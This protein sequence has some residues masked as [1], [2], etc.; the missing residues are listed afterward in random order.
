MSQS[1]EGYHPQRANFLLSFLSLEFRKLVEPYP[2]AADGTTAAN[3][4]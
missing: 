1:F 4:Y 2:F 3:Y